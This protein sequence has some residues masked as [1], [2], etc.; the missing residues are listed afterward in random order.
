MRRKIELYIGGEKADLSD[1]SFVLF[2]YAQT[3]VMK[4][5]AVKNSFTK[6]VTLPG[7]PANDAIFGCYFRADRATIGVE[8]VGPSFAAGRKTSFTIYDDLGQIIETGYVRLDEV[9]RKGRVVTGYK[10]TLFGGVGSLFYALSYTQEGEKM[11]LAD[12][13]YINVLNHTAELDFIINATN[14]TAAWNRLAAAAGAV[15]QKWD[16]IN[17]MPAYE[18]LPDGD[19]DADKGYGL[20][21]QLGLTIPSGY[22][23]DTNSGV[24]VKFAESVDGWAAKDLRSYLQRPVVSVRAMLKGMARKAKEAGLTLDYSAI[25]S[26]DYAALWKTLPAIPSIGTF[27]NESEEGR[28][29][30][31]LRP[32]V[33][34]R[35]P[36]HRLA[37]VP[38]PLEH[39]RVP[40]EPLL[41]QR[42]GDGLAR[43]CPGPRLCVQHPRRMLGRTADWS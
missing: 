37:C 29:L 16:V 36:H 31:A 3:D 7:S 2:N 38:A 32:L 41:Q 11:T 40:G 18:G 4:P 27:R 14:V 19:F 8:S 33:L 12:L 39:L 25:P 35:R 22:S 10:V 42:D 1:Q 13:T 43:L 5:T 28:G 17:F 20:W 21:Y 9:T 30:G 23:A 34:Q 6:Q 26:T 15:T 24:L